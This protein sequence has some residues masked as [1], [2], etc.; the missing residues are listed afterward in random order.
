[1]KFFPISR[2]L[3]PLWVLRIIWP[4]LESTSFFVILTV[5]VSTRSCIGDIW[6]LP[7]A[8]LQKVLKNRNFIEKGLE[9]FLTNI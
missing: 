1:M 3:R 8:R 2:R 4:K 9:K 7:R 5:N 6:N